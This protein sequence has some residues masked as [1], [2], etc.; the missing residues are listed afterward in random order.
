MESV[1]V[2]K[3]WSWMEW[4]GQR[5][6]P[7]WMHP[8]R[9]GGISLIEET[10]CTCSNCYTFC[11]WEL[12]RW[13][14]SEN[15]SGSGCIEMLLWESSTNPWSTNHCFLLASDH[16]ESPISTVRITMEI[17]EW[18]T[19][20]E[21]DLVNHLI[22]TS[23][24]VLWYCVDRHLLSKWAEHGKFTSERNV[25]PIFKTLLI[26]KEMKEE[27]IESSSWDFD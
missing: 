27:W 22:S 15:R 9:S 7:Q 14:P 24:R 8:I 19:N 6:R 4:L 5:S 1:P 3:Y 26:I 25:I 23:Q 21:L 11:W 13:R 17:R 18:A 20:G 2:I 10:A 12:E 16:K